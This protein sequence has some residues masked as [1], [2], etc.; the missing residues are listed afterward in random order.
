[1]SGITRANPIMLA[2]VA[3]AGWLAWVWLNKKPGETLGKALVTQTG[4][5]AIEVVKA[6]GGVVYEGAEMWLQDIKTAAG[7]QN[8]KAFLLDV[9]ALAGVVPQSPIE[10]NIILS[11]MP[12]AMMA[13]DGFPI[14][15]AYPA[16]KA[17]MAGRAVHEY[18]Q[19]VGIEPKPPT[20]T[21]TYREPETGIGGTG[22]YGPWWL[23]TKDSGRVN[24]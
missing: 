19:A 3:G 12:A 17:V 9:Q 6:T 4:E 5:A 2:A 15:E 18:R 21:P 16:I 22:D 10:E 1:M 23:K 11:Y 20:K 24:T 8:R 14:L 7:Q 13:L